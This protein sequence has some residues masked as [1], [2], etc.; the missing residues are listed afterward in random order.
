MSLLAVQKDGNT[1]AA[2]DTS[3]ES[4]KIITGDYN[5]RISN[6]RTGLGYQAALAAA[7]DFGLGSIGAGLGATTVNLKGGL[8][9]AS[10]DSGA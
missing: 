4:Y 10:A 5:T 1:S 8:G 3:I 2:G 6:L 7:S 9:S